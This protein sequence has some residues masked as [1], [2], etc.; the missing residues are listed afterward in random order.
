MQSLCSEGRAFVKHQQVPQSDI[1]YLTKADVLEARDAC[2]G[3]EVPE[4]FAGRILQWFVGCCPYKQNN[5]E[6]CEWVGFAGVSW[7]REEQI[8]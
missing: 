2:A 3:V 7:F 1:V 4:P 6:L 5:A 8:L